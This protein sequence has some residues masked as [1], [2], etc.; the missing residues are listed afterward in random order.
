[1]WQKGAY[2]SSHASDWKQAV[3]G[4]SG[5]W[6]P[7]SPTER[8]LFKAIP[9]VSGSLP[10]AGG[11]FGGVLLAFLVVM[12]LISIYAVF[13]AMPD[14]AGSYIFIE[15]KFV[16]LLNGLLVVVGTYGVSNSFLHCHCESC[17]ST[18]FLCILF[19]LFALATC[20]LDLGV[21]LL[22][23]R[24][25]YPLCR[26]AS[27]I[28]L[29]AVPPFAS[30]L[31]EGTPGMF[32]MASWVLAAVAVGTSGVE[33]ILFQTEPPQQEKDADES[34]E[35]QQKD[36]VEDAA[37]SAPVAVISDLPKKE[38]AVSVVES[39]MFKQ[40]AGPMRDSWVM[41]KA[42]SSRHSGSAKHHAA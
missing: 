30:L 7:A 34:K 21:G 35:E 24:S 29:A 3:V 6:Q 40:L 38:A 16:T 2:T 5:E 9:V 11:V 31:A 37:A 10:I 26:V 33:Y 36:T 23:P 15:P 39:N 18:S 17:L 42:N 22:L 13:M 28:L 1:V 20:V 41:Q 8:N 19:S 12:F 27:S 4:S 14:G 32:Q 25:M